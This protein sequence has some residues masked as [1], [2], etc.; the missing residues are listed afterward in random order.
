[1]TGKSLRVF[2]VLF[3]TAAFS[4]ASAQTPPAVVITDLET[5]GGTWTEAYAMNNQGQVVGTSAT[6]TGENH[7]FLWQNGVMLDLGT[8]GGPLSGAGGINEQGQVI[9][10]SDTLSG[11]T[12]AFIWQNGVMTDLG[13]LPG[14][15]GRTEPIAINNLGQIVGRW[16]SPN[17]PDRGFIW[18]NG[19]MTD[20]GTL[21][22]KGC[23][24]ADIND[25]G[26]IIGR[27]NTAQVGI[28]GSGDPN[29]I[30]SYSHPFVWHNGVMTDLNPHPDTSGT[31]NEYGWV[32][33][34]NNQ[35]QV[36]GAGTSPVTGGATGFVWENGE[37]T[38]ID[39]GFPNSINDAGQ[40]AGGSV[41]AF[42]WQNGTAT[43]LG[44]LGGPNSAAYFIN[45]IGQ[46]TGISETETGV[47]HAYFWE[48]GV[49]TDLDLS[50]ETHSDIF[51]M[52]D[53]GQVLAFTHDGSWNK[54]DEFFW[55][56]GIKTNLNQ[57]VANQLGP[58]S[59]FWTTSINNQGKVLA[60]VVLL[61]GSSRQLL[62][63]VR[64]PDPLEQTAVLIDQVADLNLENGIDNSL[65]GKIESSVQALTDLNTNNDVAAANKLVA[66]V[67][68]VEA[69]RGNMISDADADR[70]V[71]S[72]VKIINK[73]MN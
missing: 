12:R 30:P 40:I 45:A 11:Q 20:L 4:A 9:G 38:Y 41:E 71:G 64:P 70:L 27:S 56:E 43:A 26:Q 6:A 31:P 37:A 16:E 65:D 22:G 54:F 19:V 29:S 53:L 23:Q 10:T 34:L 7:A 57:E 61:D 73:I 39:F 33:G 13:A 47:N 15:T 46:I 51:R 58:F 5:L 69:Q 8:L 21:G 55:E 72:A 60:T 24:P 18:Q 68:H 3:S 36:I 32:F 67:N 52:N 1:M 63:A 48:S 28:P 66:F 17:N 44:N 59:N 14:A 62:L 50:V 2:T 35:G 42:I 49:M 25:L